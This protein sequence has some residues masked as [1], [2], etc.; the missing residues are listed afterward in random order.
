MSLINGTK[1][2]Y[3]RRKLLP[4]PASRKLAKRKRK[5]SKY[6]YGKIVYIRDAVHERMRTLA[7]RL[8]RMRQLQ[9]FATELLDAQLHAAET[10]PS[11]ADT[12]RRPD[13]G[14]RS[15]SQPG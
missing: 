12:F 15:S 8:G 3:V 2:K 13:H 9:D 5:K 1:R 11:V 4:I 14:P 6:Y 10:D 7:D